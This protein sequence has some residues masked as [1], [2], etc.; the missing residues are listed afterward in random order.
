MA[1]TP[2]QLNTARTI[3]AV[4]KSV[5][6]SGKQI[7]AALLTGL[8]ES[9]LNP[10]AVNAGS[11]ATGWRQE[12]KSSYP[13]QNRR[14]AAGQAQRFYAET[15]GMG[16]RSWDIADRV[17]RAGVGTGYLSAHAGEAGALMR[18]L[19]GVGG[20][21]G[22]SQAGGSGGSAPSMRIQKG[23]QSTD[24]NAALLDAL[25]SGRKNPVTGA[26]HA[27]ESGAYTTQNADK[28]IQA[29][30]DSGATPA[31]YGA[32]QGRVKFGPTA[33]RVGMRTSSKVTDFVKQIAGLV[34]EDLVIGTG[35][36]HSRMTANG[37]VSD[38]W[39]GHAADIP[40]VGRHLVRL[41]QAALIA[42]GMSPDQAHKQVGGL[43]NVGGHQ[44]IFNC[45]GL[46]CGGDHTNHLHVSAH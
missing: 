8:G 27:V 9:N 13:T 32:T 1:Y 18:Q 45:S 33:D 10:N 22:N 24:I 2:S 31:R 28:L 20:G 34:G 16:G 19:G 30:Q 17:Q 25:I 37:N 12:I 35:T 41:G 21:I 38:H 40:A 7:K 44:V 14:D 5:G 42:A 15:K 6:A 36:N 11:G 23:G 43:F 46:K 26:L 3:I 29:N 4:G 39:S